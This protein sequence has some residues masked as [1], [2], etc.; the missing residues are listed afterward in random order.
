MKQT[1]SWFMDLSTS[2]D[3]MQVIQV[4]AGGVNVQKRLFPFFSAYKYFKLG[5]V[6][7]RF[8]PAATLPI[9]PTGLSYEAGENT[10]DPRDQFNPGLVRITNGENVA[11]DLEELFSA[12]DR[13]E[14]IYYNMMLDK[15]WYKF[16]LQSGMK[17]SAFPKF[18]SVAQVKQSRLTGSV[19]P[20]LATQ[21]TTN[22]EKLVNPD[23]LGRQ[24]LD[25][26]AG[27]GLQIYNMDDEI[28]MQTGRKE[29][30]GWMPTDFFIKPANP[31]AISTA[32]SGENIPGTYGY[33][34]VPEIDLITIVL[35][36]AY[37]TKYFYRVYVEEEVYFK[38]PV[39]LG[40]ND[41]GELDRFIRFNGSVANPGASVPVGI[42]ENNL[43][44]YD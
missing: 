3:M 17:R 11:G 44:P 14:P 4:T 19:R 27:S 42:P 29:P 43:T 7:L 13:S 20:E 30:M 31:N 25:Y 26:G 16:Q 6:S 22:N 12:S 40:Y 15:R 10:V 36:K 33:N 9:D 5:K 8:V 21:N 2:P 23:G 35:P 39:V 1:F 18:W 24:I 37:K 41:A 34:K 32:V 28:L 38:D